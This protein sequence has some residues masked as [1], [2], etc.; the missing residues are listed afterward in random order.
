MRIPTSSID[1]VVDILVEGRGKLRGTK[2]GLRVYYRNALNAYDKYKRTGC[3][4][5]EDLI[6]KLL[7]L[8]LIH[9]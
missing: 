1:H 4:S 9:I 2:R 5:E 7:R 6:R 8:S 3:A